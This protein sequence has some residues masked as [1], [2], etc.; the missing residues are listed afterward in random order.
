ME[1]G[2]ANWMRIAVE[3]VA[4]AIMIAGVVGAF[5]DRYRAKRGADTR[6]I[7]LLTMTL[8]LPTILILSLEEVL[9]R[10]TAAALVGV[11]V[12]YALS[13]IGRDKGAT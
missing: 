13:G 12:G 6:A 2:P 8:L 3:I 11:V 5:I 7:Q 1:T 4:C 9:N 10:Q